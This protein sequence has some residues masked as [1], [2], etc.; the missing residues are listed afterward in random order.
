MRGV[1]MIPIYLKIRN[2]MI[3]QIEKGILIPGDRIPSE[4]ELVDLFKVSRMTVRH[5]IDQLVNDGILVRMV[6]KGTY[7][8]SEKFATELN[9]LRSFSEEI[10]STGHRPSAKLIRIERGQAGN[11]VTSLLRIDSSHEV[12]RVERLRLV[13]DLEMAIT[14]SYFPLSRAFPVDEIDFSATSI[15]NQIESLGLRIEKA[16]ETVTAEAADKRTANFLRVKDKAP[17]L[18]ITR[19]TFISNN[20]PIEYMEGLF[21]PDRYFISQELY[22]Q[23]VR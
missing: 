9:V 22:R 19:L 18:K 4:R 17:L 14:V 13:D 11:S 7:V 23:E 3:K 12:M 15:Y 5:A 20:V 2:Y 16:T 10:I 21:R 6:G 8:S 1:N